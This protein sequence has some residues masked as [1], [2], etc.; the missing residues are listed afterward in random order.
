MSIQTI[1]IV[2]IDRNKKF[3]YT[4]IY[5]KTNDHGKSGNRAWCPQGWS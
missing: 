3:L 4:F 5:G 1:F 2:I